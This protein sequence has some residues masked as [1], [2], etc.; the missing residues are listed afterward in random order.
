MNI[1]IPILC[2][3]SFDL[4]KFDFGFRDIAI[5]DISSKEFSE[6]VKDLE[7][8]NFDSNFNFFRII[9]E[10]IAFP[11]DR[12]F[13]I[14]KNNPHN[15][16]NYDDLFNVWKLLLII[17]PSDLQVEY[18]VELA[19]SFGILSPRY[20]YQNE[21][22]I[23]GE[24]PGKLLVTADEYVPEINE[25]IKLVF[26]RLKRQNFISIAI[27]NY[28]QS[29]F[30][31]QK[32][33]QYLSLIFSLETIIEKGSELSYRLNRS[34]AIIVGEDFDASKMI[35]KNM[36]SIYTL[37]SNIV[38]NGKNVDEKIENKIPFLTSLVSRV[39]IELLVH[40]IENNKLLG[41]K[42]TELGF[43]DGYKISKHWKKF[44]LNLLTKF[45]ANYYLM[46]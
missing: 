34:I 9:I 5:L 6:Y 32:S 46:K 43:G 28:V 12:K 27:E 16:Y 30:S 13:A 7:P 29:F 44:E 19:K 14:V 45:E 10:K 2:G 21:R 39:I 24:Y 3:S 31:S 15:K 41:D 38:H 36:K 26:E 18:E 4:S 1:K 20:M 25:F 11:S 40:N 22:N 8:E 17:F 33:F 35:F 42:L 23:T 37:R